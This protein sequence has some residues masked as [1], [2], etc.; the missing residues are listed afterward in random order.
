MNGD[1]EGW[2]GQGRGRRFEF[3]VLISFCSFV[4]VS[5]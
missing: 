4:S 5:S 3:E 1:R 2:K